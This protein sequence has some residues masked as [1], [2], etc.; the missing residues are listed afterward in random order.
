MRNNTYQSFSVAMCVYYK[1]NP[2]WFK[3]A[4]ES[5]L[6]QTIKPNEIVLVVDGP[7][8]E[9]LD[10]I[11]K[12]Y[13]T[14]VIF[15]VI[16]LAENVGHGN[17]RRKG[18]ENCSFDLVALMDADDVCLPDRFEKQLNVFNE[19]DDVSAVGGNISEFIGEEDNIVGYRN[20]PE[21][22]EQIVEY[23]K[24]RCPLNQMTVILKKYDV[25]QIGGYIDWYCNEDYYLWIR[26]YLAGK[27]FYNV[28]ETLVNV[29]VGK[30]MYA[31]RGGWKYFKS[32]RA[33]QKLM[34]KNKI[35]GFGTY[36]MNVLKRFIV[37]VLLPN[38][39]RAWVFKKFA[40]N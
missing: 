28:Q 38:K 32:E 39:L 17:A 20:V 10:G 3:R 37:Q 24:K 15:K 34:R 19:N 25:E 33:I 18:L 35:I 13:E 36:F 21:N 27:K 40:R 4:V 30:D 23:M 29:R 5:V 2:E 9:E 31:R 6:N 22:H 26:M 12:E 1:D 11:I 7:V 8:G 16:R 14:N